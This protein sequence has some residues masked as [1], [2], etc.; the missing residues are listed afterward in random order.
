MANDSCGRLHSSC[1]DTDNRIW[2]FTNW[3]RPFCLS[4]SV[5]S[6]PDNVPKQIECGWMFSSMLTKS[7]DVFVWWPLE[8]PIGTLV[9]QKMREMDNEG[10]QMANAEG[11]T[12]PCV[13]WDM[14]LPPIRLP[15]IPSLPDFTDDGEEPQ[16]IQIAAFENSIVGLTN[17]G[18]VLKFDSLHDE[19]EVPRGHWEYVNLILAFRQCWIL[20]VTLSSRNLVNCAH[21]QR[22]LYSL[23]PTIKIR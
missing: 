19:T 20:S 17:L 10:D 16:L 1:L 14:E 18:H 7:G 21:W 12:I 5:L 4:S 15:P 9:Q 22:L 11:T 6:D 13:P 23:R 2:T 8:G 3:G